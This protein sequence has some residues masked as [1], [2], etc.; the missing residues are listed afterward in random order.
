MAGLSY[1][2][3]TTWRYENAGSANLLSTSGTTLTNLPNTQSKTG[4]AFYQTQ[5]AKC[6]D[7]PATNEIW[8]KFDVY[9]NGSQ[10]W[11][12]YN[13]G[14]NG[15]TGIASQTNGTLS[16]F[17]H[18][19]SFQKD[20]SNLCIT[21]QL[22]TILLH[23]LSGSS[24]GII[25]A[26]VNGS[27]IY[28]YTGDVN[29]GQDFADIYLQSDG[30]GTFFSNVIIS[31]VEIDLNENIVSYDC[32][33][34]PEIYISWIPTGKI[35]LKPQIYAT[36]IP[37]PE[38]TNVD[39][40]RKVTNSET[41]T[42]DLSRK[43]IQNENNSA[44]LLRKV[45]DTEKLSADTKRKISVEEI[46]SADTFRRV[47]QA[48]TVQSDTYREVKDTEKIIADTSRK[49]GLITVHN[50]LLRK[51][52]VTTTAPV[53]TC[54]QVG[55]SEKISAD[56]Y[57]KIGDGSP[58]SARTYRKVTDSE[59]IIADTLLKLGILEEI[60]ADTKRTVA[61]HEKTV[62]DIFLQMTTTEK[63]NV[64]LRRS[65]L[66]FVRAD[67]FRRVT[68]SEKTLARTVIQVP[69]IMK[70]IVHPTQR[71]LNKS[72]KRL[73]GDEPQSYIGNI[74]STLDSYGATSINISLNERTLSD[75]LTFDIT[76]S[77]IHNSM[78]G[79]G[80]AI[81]ATFLDYTFNCIVEETTQTDRIMTVKAKYKQ[82]DLLYTWFDLKDIIAAAGT[83]DEKSD[84]E[85]EEE[86]GGEEGG[87]S[88]VIGGDDDDDDSEEEEINSPSAIQFIR[89]VA[90]ALGFSKNDIEVRMDRFTPTN[91]KNDASITYSDV[92]SNLFSWTSRVPQQQINVFLRG[93]KFYCI[94]RGKENKNSTFDITNLPHSRPTIHKKK[95]R[96]LC[97]NP[98]TANSVD[99]DDDDKKKFFSGTI[100]YSMPGIAPYQSSAELK[101]V[102]QNG[103]LDTEHISSATGL[104]V[105]DAEE[106]VRLT[107]SA[108]TKYSYTTLIDGQHYISSKT[109]E[110]RTV[111]QNME[112][113]QTYETT[114]SVSTS[115]GYKTSK[116]AGKN[117]E[118]YL[119][120]EKEQ[121]KN[122]ETIDGES[123]TSSIIRDIL[124]S[125]A[126][127][128]FYA[129]TIFQ[130]G[131]L[132]GANLSQGK[133]GNAVSQFTVDQA[134]NTLFL[135]EDN[136][137]EQPE[138]ET[139]DQLS[140]I[141][142][143]SFPVDSKTKKKLNRALQSL[144]GSI[145]T[146]ITVDLISR[147]TNGVPEI[148]HIV[149]FTGRVRL[150]EAEYYL[151]SNNITVTPRKL[152]QKLQLIRWEGL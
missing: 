24:D 147:I 25:E 35:Y 144:N 63:V 38:K 30:S 50:D 20:F 87:I 47:V 44:D 19:G 129:Q 125:P 65:L 82:E 52:N 10:R 126:G 70:H 97:Q 14:T 148:T 130:N 64:D 109:S 39:L 134:Q 91:L 53:D 146:T 33:I 36:Y 99:D 89:A 42:A 22:Q 48:D 28:T 151:V 128:G 86:S 75:E 101:L 110:S 61:I 79:V 83:E 46:F 124:H 123:T 72:T 57:L 88:I 113:L 93:G 32:A 143:S 6:F 90:R 106:I 84:S 21:N 141:E 103:L 121:T 116:E 7:L 15:D 37:E 133:P 150:D 31:N 138:E 18:G 94:Q 105:N 45:V 120:H 5:R 41:T 152:I 149:D 68:R 142:D 96:V 58:A 1:I 29:H 76:K 49:I 102:Y 122:T 59:T 55:I 27:K 2:D 108:T 104:F 17:T 127:N 73:L 136:E 92:V 131:I 80:E 85:D 111:E 100:S 62:A 74:A 135:E 11:R 95:V 77:P 107:N 139:S 9:F 67:T 60:S 43:V 26:W 23:M 3:A 69:H 51:V 98:N 145:E 132:Q 8:I 118:V 66:D 16:Y 81:Q 119:F 114:Q 71:L 13:G 34:K 54:R 40:L 112:T 137:E 56:T 12:A 4:K 117:T 140:M 78:P 115:Y